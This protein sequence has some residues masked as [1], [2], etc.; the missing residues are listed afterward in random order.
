MSHVQAQQPRRQRRPKSTT[1]FFPPTTIEHGVAGTASVED[2][3]K[4]GD[5]RCGSLLERGKIILTL[6]TITGISLSVD[7]YG[8]EPAQ[9][10]TFYKAK[11]DVILI[12]RRSS[13][14]SKG[15]GAEHDRALFRCPVISRRHA[16]ITF[17]QYGNVR[18]PHRIRAP[19]WYLANIGICMRLEIAP[20]HSNPSSRRDCVKNDRAR[21]P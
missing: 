14:S 15:P 17:T 19:C 9:I 18:I 3:V 2:R 11:A 20:R 1:P 4:H 8:D 16:K 5:Y 7:K 13:V 12:G 21:Y 6:R 10:L